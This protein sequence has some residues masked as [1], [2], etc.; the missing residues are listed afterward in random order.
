MPS[1]ASEM[2]RPLLGD[3]GEVIEDNAGTRRLGPSANPRARRPSCPRLDVP[4]P[5]SP[6]SL[7]A[8]NICS[9]CSCKLPVRRARILSRRARPPKALVA[10]SLAV[11]LSFSIR[12]PL[13]E[14]PSSTVPEQRALTSSS[15]TPRLWLP[16]SRSYG[17]KPLLVKPN[18]AGTM[19][20]LHKLSSLGPGHAVHQF[21]PEQPPGALSK[22]LSVS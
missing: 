11:Q 7:L 8:H 1:S 5:F 12:R 14:L 22:V 20:I 21:V 3:F 10:V 17:P 4:P 2:T 15:A 16:V 6:S 18:R 19:Q 9:S 13:V